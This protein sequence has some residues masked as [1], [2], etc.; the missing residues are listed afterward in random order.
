M[1]RNNICIIGITH[2]EE[3]E[4]GLARNP[5]IMAFCIPKM[6]SQ[7]EKFLEN[8]IYSCNNNKNNDNNK[9]PR[10]KL[11]EGGKRPVL[12]NYRILNREIEEDTNKWKHISFGIRRINIIKMSILPTAIYRFNSTPAKIPSA[13]FTD[14]DQIFQKFIWNRKGA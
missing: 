2:G 7:K 11:N 6:N 1:K 5:E 3:S 14:L 4:Q 9:I 13:Y 12:K 10:N 8:T